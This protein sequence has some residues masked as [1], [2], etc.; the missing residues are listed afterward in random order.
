MSFVFEKSRV[1]KIGSKQGPIKKNMF[2]LFI[3][4][5]SQCIDIDMDIDMSL[6]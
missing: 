6:A 2:M 1:E 5:I 4:D 3:S